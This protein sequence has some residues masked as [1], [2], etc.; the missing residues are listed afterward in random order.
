MNKQYQLLGK[1]CLLLMR[2]TWFLAMD[3]EM[4]FHLRVVSIFKFIL[5]YNRDLMWFYIFAASTHDQEV[6]SFY[7][8]ENTYCN[9][10]EEVL[11]RY[12]ELVPQLRL[13]GCNLFLP[14]PIILIGWVVDFGR[15]IPFSCDRAHFI[16]PYHWNGHHYCWAKWWTIS[17]VS[18]NSWWAGA[19]VFVCILYLKNFVIE[20]L[21]TSKFYIETVNCHR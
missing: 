15:F 2:I 4:V 14:F 11:R 21:V 9:G 20:V 19:L 10:F 16:C 17:C 3:L 13:A 5:L 7:P 1:H 6:F 18:D 12:R 8:D